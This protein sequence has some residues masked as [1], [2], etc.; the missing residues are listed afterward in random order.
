M[1]VVALQGLCVLTLSSDP[2]MLALPASRTAGVIRLYNLLVGGG[3]LLC[4][5]AAHKSPVVRHQHAHQCL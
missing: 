4:E 1:L 3:A 2:C 5:I